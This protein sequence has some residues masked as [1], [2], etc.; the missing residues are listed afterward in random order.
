M[1]IINYKIYKANQHKF[2][3]QIHSLKEVYS[4]FQ[5]LKG[6][7]N[8]VST[9]FML[10]HLYNLIPAIEKN[11]IIS[12]SVCI[13]LGYKFNDRQYSL[14]EIL[15]E[16]SSYFAEEVKEN[17][18]LE[19][20]KTQ[21]IYFLLYL[22][23]SFDFNHFYNEFYIYANDFM[24]KKNLVNMGH[25][26]LNDSFFIP[27]FL[28]FKVDTI[29]MAVYFITFQLTNETNNSFYVFIRSCMKNNKDIELCA[30]EIIDLYI[31]DFDL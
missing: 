10:F 19:C 22:N 7:S 16:V 8:I 24:L 31:E 26:I 15:Q 27:L 17:T 12:Y 25:T 11:R 1:K 4:I 21:E 5:K 2:K 29:L 14:N 20:I 18:I 3:S 9:S 6:N 13:L 23:F 28:I 30:N